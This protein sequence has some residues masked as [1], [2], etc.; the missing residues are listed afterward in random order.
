STTGIPLQEL[1]GE[2]VV[3]FLA[4]DGTV[5]A[6]E[7]E[8]Y[9]WRDPLR[10][11]YPW[12]EALEFFAQNDRIVLRVADPERGPDEWWVYAVSSGQVLYRSIARPDFVPVRDP[13]KVPPRC[14]SKELSLDAIPELP[15]NDLGFVR[16]EQPHPVET[17][18]ELVFRLVDSRGRLWF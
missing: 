8:P 5:R 4:P 15:K 17:N 10:A 6:T 18:S 2:L 9:V 14:K 13:A 11:P 1:E 12:V 16:F 3:A 7:S